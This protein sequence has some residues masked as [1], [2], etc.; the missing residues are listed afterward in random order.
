M[1]ITFHGDSCFTI[2]HNKTKIIFSPYAKEIGL[3]EAQLEGD[4][5]L[6][7]RE[8][9]PA[10][11]NTKAVKGNP[12]IFDWPGEYEAK[13]VSIQGITAYNFSQEDGEENTGETTLFV[14]R[15][16]DFSICHL[17]GLGH[18]MPSRLID[19]IGDIDILF[20]PVGGKGSISAKKAEEVV[21]QI[22]PR[23]AIPMH[24]AEEGRKD[25]LAPVGDFL[26]EVGASSMA[27]REI[28]EPKKAELDVEKTEIVVLVPQR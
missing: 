17:G 28:Y 6:V 22:E 13:D 2:E 16:E 25:T 7:A 26:K 9:D 8:N 14:V 21:S 24:Y 27:P 1:K 15:F 5:V 12:V 18:R 23:I 20:V 4:I 3:K 19:K 10:Y 11:N